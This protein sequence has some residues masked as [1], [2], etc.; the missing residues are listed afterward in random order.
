MSITN[1]L[2]AYHEGKIFP[3]T[4]RFG[5]AARKTVAFY[6]VVGLLQNGEDTDVFVHG[7]HTYNGYQKAYANDVM[8][9][10]LKAGIAD[11]F[12]V[13][14]AAYSKGK[15][16]DLTDEAVAVLQPGAKAASDMGEWPPSA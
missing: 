12:N 13:L 8:K 2:P 9:I 1:D 5:S 16:P 15:I 14:M 4:V 11:V 3:L 7:D 10:S 6:Q